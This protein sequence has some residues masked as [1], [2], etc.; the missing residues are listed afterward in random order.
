MHS[1][2]MP[3]ET[4]TNA[5]LTAAAVRG[6]GS[7]ANIDSLVTGT[8]IP[9]QLLP[10]HGVMVHGELGIPA[11]EVASTAG[12]C[13]AGLTARKYAYMAVLCSLAKNA[14]ASDLEALSGV[15][16]A[17][18]FAAESEHRVT[19][20]DKHPE[21]AFEKDFLRWMLSDGAGAFLL[22]NRPTDSKLSLRIE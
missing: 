17:R 22:Q 5:Q 11:C 15:L 3:S 9:A 7:T 14:V 18:N 6:L 8:S 20:L 19:E 1:I 21:L 12:I 16:H 2:T 4:H 13:L 10:N